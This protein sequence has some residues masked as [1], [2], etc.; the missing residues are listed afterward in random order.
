MWEQNSSKSEKMLWR[1]YW[2][3][4]SDLVN[5]WMDNG[6]LINTIQ[7]IIFQ[8]SA[9]LAK[10]PSSSNLSAGNKEKARVWV[11]D[12]A[13]QFLKQYDSDRN[14]YSGVNILSRLTSTIHK[15]DNEVQL[16]ISEYY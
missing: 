7:L 6:L 12:R 5:G 15:L 9:A 16:F 2:A 3:H 10:C 4:L 13:V 14:S 8:E 11:R 1:S